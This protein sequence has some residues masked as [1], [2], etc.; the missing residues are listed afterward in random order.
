MEELKDEALIISTIKFD[1][2]YYEKRTSK[3]W[4]VTAEDLGQT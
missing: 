2:G 3:C 4:L 1:V